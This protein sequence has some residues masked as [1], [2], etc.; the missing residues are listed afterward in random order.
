MGQSTYLLPDTEATLDLSCFGIKPGTPLAICRNG[1]WSCEEVPTD[2][3]I[4]VEG[5][6]GVMTDFNRHDLPVTCPA[7]AEAK[8][9]CGTPAGGG[10]G[11]G[12]GEGAGTTPEEVRQIVQACLDEGAQAGIDAKTGG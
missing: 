5:I 9:G 11:T 3:K 6:C 12:G 7:D 8:C 2:C 1:C 10:G 4:V